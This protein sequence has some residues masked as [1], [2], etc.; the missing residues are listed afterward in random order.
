MNIANLIAERDQT[1]ELFTKT[2][3]KLT[4]AINNL[5]R[6]NLN[7]AA[8]DFAGIP[9]RR[10]RR[11]FNKQYADD[12]AQAA[13]NAWIELQY[14]WKPLI[15]EAQGAGESLAKLALD[16]RTATAEAK[17]SVSLSH[18]RVL[19][20]NIK[21]SYRKCDTKIDCKGSVIYRVDPGWAH[22]LS[23]IGL[24][25]PLSP[26]WELTPWSFIIDWFIPVGDTIA[27]LDAV[28]GATF[29]TG[30]RTIHITRDISTMEIYSRSGY[31]GFSV[32]TRREIE[33][34]RTPFFDFPGVPMMQF[35]SPLSWAHA[36]NALALAVQRIR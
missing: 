11:R 28:L 36:A 27:A 7:A 26:A 21:D 29:V 8:K 13:A 23:G 18:E 2:A 32:L 14:G 20:E 16:R 25:N 19:E 34:V 9:S 6:G 33:I 31:S 24:T 35:K 12:R 17:K 4:S 15:A 1:L 22:W 10:G 5:R 3:R 30:S